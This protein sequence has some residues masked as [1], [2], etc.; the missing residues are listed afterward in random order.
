MAKKRRS[1]GEGSVYQLPNGTWRGQVTTGINP[2]TGKPKRQSFTGKTRSEVTQKMTKALH[3]LQT[4]SYIE[5]STLTV[6]QW[7]EDWLKGRKPHIEESTYITYETMIRCHIKPELGEFKLRNLRTRDIQNL[8][9]SKMENGRFDGKG[10]LSTRTVKYIYSTIQSALGQALKE[11]LIP[12]NPADA[13]ELPKQTKKEIETLTQ[14]EVSKFLSTAKEDKADLIRR[15]RTEETKTIFTYQSSL[16][17]NLFY[18]EL[19]SGLRRGELLGLVWDDIDFENEV[20]NVKRQLV[21]SKEKG[22]ILKNPKTEGSIRV[23]KIDNITAKKLKTHKVN[24]SKVKLILT[25]ERFKNT[26][27]LVFCNEE[28]KPIDPRN[29]ARHF[30]FLLKKAEIRHFRL[31]DLRHTHA[32]L[33]LEAG[34]DMKSMQERLGHT[35]F[36]TTAD[37]YSHVTKKMAEKAANII[38]GVLEACEK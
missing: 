10:E 25:D 37:T 5:P 7:L 32:T 23:I 11:R 31:H 3:E 6:S 36:K 2:K 21:R 8:I 29:L 22:L 30:D 15:A 24:Q 14:E 18:L 13:V 17:Y 16:Y 4:G 9:N 1:N 26:N 19:A 34:A 28:G 20:I 38:G 27:N 33:S 35:T 12:Y